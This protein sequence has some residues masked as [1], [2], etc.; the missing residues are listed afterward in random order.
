[1]LS[2]LSQS[3]QGTHSSALTVSRTSD[4]DFKK[5][6]LVIWLDGDKVCDLMFGEV[7]SRNVAPG[8]H[9]LRVSNTLVWKTVKFEV[10]PGEEVRFELV[11]RPGWLTYPMLLTLGAGPLFLTVNRIS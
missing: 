7:F 11:N 10:T 2:S 9:T 8:K 5:R 6:Q 4:D 1:M 3:A